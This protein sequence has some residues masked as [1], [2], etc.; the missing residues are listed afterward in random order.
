MSRMLFV[1]S[2]AWL[3]A[4]DR[5]QRGHA[6]VVAA[7]RQARKGRTS[8]VTS[9]YVLDETLTLVRAR[10]G[11]RLALTIGDAVWRKGGAEL[12]LVDDPIR[13]NA[14]EIFTKYAEHDLSF[15][16]CT[17]AALMRQRG[18]DTICSLDHHFVVL[19][20]TRIPELP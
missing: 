10:V 19:G 13:E 3:A 9:D 12:L 2:S 20:F 11:H 15:T 7:L 18:L 1:D 16:D 17:S 5:G 14:W 8:I 4:Y 6:E